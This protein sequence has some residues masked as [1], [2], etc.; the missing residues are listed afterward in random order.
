MHHI[1]G[2]HT[3]DDDIPYATIGHMPL[4][5]TH[6]PFEVL[7]YELLFANQIACLSDY[8]KMIVHF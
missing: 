4:V 7:R 5:A 8:D 3:S 1:D 2:T 6:L